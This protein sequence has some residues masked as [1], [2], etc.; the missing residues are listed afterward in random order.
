MLL[1]FLGLDLHLS[2]VARSMGEIQVLLANEFLSRLFAVGVVD[3][4]ELVE[5]ILMASLGGDLQVTYSNFMIAKAVV[6]KA[7][8]FVSCLYDSS[9]RGYSLKQRG[10]FLIEGHSVA[11][12]VDVPN[13]H[14]SP[15]TAE[16][17]G[18]DPT[19]EC[20][21]LIFPFSIIALPVS[22]A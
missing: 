12:V 17:D 11:M 4:S 6:F 19:I 3:A 15:S 8:D 2:L 5:G 13:K 20:L 18:L 21:Q 16:F 14:A 1:P 9:Q 22:C 10:P 7:A